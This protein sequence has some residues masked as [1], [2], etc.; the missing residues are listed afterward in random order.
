MSLSNILTKVSDVVLSNA[1]QKVIGGLGLSVFTYGTT[2][3][4]FS[5]AMSTVYEYWGSMGDLMFLMGLSGFDK[6][7]S[8]VFSAIAVRVAMNSAKVGIKKAS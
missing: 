6:A 3:A 4:I 8:M 5:K 1:G 7:M 2:Q